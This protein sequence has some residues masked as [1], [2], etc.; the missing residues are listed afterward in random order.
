MKKLFLTILSTIILPGAY[1]QSTNEIIDS[2][3][4]NSE[5]PTYARLKFLN[6]EDCK[7]AVLIAK[8]DIKQETILLLIVGGIGPIEYTTDKAF[9]EK[10]SLIYHDYGDLAAPKDCIIKYNREIFN[11]LTERYGK[12]W[13]REARKDVYG[14]KE[15]KKKKKDGT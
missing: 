13:I 4:A 15:W 5:L 10:Y 9:Q 6:G 14:F 3:F 7:T 12:A 8:Q 1:S 11:Y 2:S